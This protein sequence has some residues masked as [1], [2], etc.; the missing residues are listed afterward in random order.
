MDDLVA[1]AGPVRA[2]RLFGPIIAMML[3]GLSL[4]ALLV[5]LLIHRFDA[6]AMQREGEMVRHGFELQNDDL[7]AVIVPQVNWDEA[8]K[9]LDHGV[10]LGWADFN[11]GN[12]L[13]T[14]NGFTRVFVINGAGQPVYAAADGK[15]VRLDRADEFAGIT[16]QLIAPLRRAEAARPP[17]RPGADGQSVVTTPI[18]SAGVLQVGDKVYV[19]IA[20]L[21]QPDFGLILPRSRQAP[22]AITAIPVNAAMLESFG[23]RY[24]LDGLRLLRPD[25]TAPGKLQLVLRSPTGVA[26]GKLVWTPRAVGTIL[27]TNLVIPVLATIVLMALLAW[28]I[29]RRGEGVVRDLVASEARAKHLA[30]HDPLTQL[31]NRALLFERLRH[32]LADP[33]I[34]DRPVAVFCLDLDRFKDV[35]DSLGHPAGDF[36]ISTTARRLQALCDGRGTI[37]RLG[38]DEFVALQRC[39]SEAEALDLAQRIRADLAQPVQSEF[40]AMEVGAS[41]GLALIARRDVEAGEA[42]RWADIAMYRAKEDGRNRVTLF[43]PSMDTVLR[44]RRELE[45]DLRAALAADQLHMVYQPQ[46]DRSG[47]VRGLEALLRWEHPQH[48]AISPGLFVPL[49]EESGLINALGEFVL[50][51][52]FVETRQWPQVRIAV[53]ISPIQLRS[54]DFAA[55]VTQ[56]AAEQGIALGRYEIEVTETALLGDD[57]ATADN[58]ERFKQLGLSIALDDF[59]TGYSSLSVLQTYSVDRIKIDRAFVGCLGLDSNANALVAAMVHLAAALDLGII[60][61]GVETDDQM[62][63]LIGCGC[64][65]FQGHLFGEPMTAPDLNDWLSARTAKPT[66]PLRKQA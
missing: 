49:A 19:V 46:V 41:I 8:V 3:G 9:A 16:A 61:E 13:Y 4:L 51:R 55:L 37:A 42:L 33:A 24:L 7:K 22:V 53:N 43:E 57:R 65:E 20:T 30:F 63:R 35:N 52:V 45:S 10:D 56:L 12:Y 64:H 11:L 23:K 6:S 5:V 18:Q 15:R 28:T 50:R 2:A 39:A 26:V 31:P 32:A 25:Q 62:L 36:L 47:T 44:K 34:A 59:G 29:I 1:P 48:G 54:P 17:I 58:I 14:F 21:V 38:G 60:A 40:G 27:F 66:R